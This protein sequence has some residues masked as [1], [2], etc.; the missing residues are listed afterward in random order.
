[1]AFWKIIWNFPKPIYRSCGQNK[2]P[3]GLQ[4]RNEI[5]KSTAYLFYDY[6]C[7]QSTFISTVTYLSDAYS[8]Y[9]VGISGVREWI[10]CIKWNALHMPFAEAKSHT[11]TRAQM[12]VGIWYSIFDMCGIIN[13]VRN[14]IWICKDRIKTQIPIVLF[15]H[16]ISNFGASRFLHSR[17]QCLLFIQAWTHTPHKNDTKLL[18]IKHSFI[19]CI[20]IYCA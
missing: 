16:H 19:R 3:P 8:M 15:K 7:V 12:F 20:I 14:V 2:L 13:F 18:R 17:K 4:K 9:Y 5:V 1:M 10:E 6:H 11:H